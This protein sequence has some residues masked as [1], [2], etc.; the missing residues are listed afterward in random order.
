MGQNCVC[1]FK[2]FETEGQTFN[3]PDINNRNQAIEHGEVLQTNLTKS[4]ISQELSKTHSLSKDAN[5]LSQSKLHN[6]EIAIS[7][8]HK[9][10]KGFLFRKKYHSYLKNQL[11]NYQEE[12]LKEIT[13]A[14]LSNSNILATENKYQGVYTQLGWK[15]YYDYNENKG[16]MIFNNDNPNQK[17]YKNCVYIEY[18]SNNGKES[19]INSLVNK[20]ISL[21]KG[22]VTIDNKRHGYGELLTKENKQKGEWVNDAFTGWNCIFTSDG[23]MLIGKYALGVLNG[24]GEC[25]SLDGYS[26]KGS[27]VNNLKEGEGVEVM[28]NSTY[29]GSFLKD[30]K[31][32]KGKIVFASGDI[33][34]GNFV[35]G[36]IEGKG[37]YIW[38]ISKHEYIGD[39]KGGKFHGNGYYK[40]N[41]E[42]Y[43]KGEY[44]DGVKEGIGEITFP[45]KMKYIGPFANGK[46][47]GVGVFDNGKNFK[48]EA[49]FIDGKINK[50]YKQRK[51]G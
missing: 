10:T 30:M 8:F 23:H 46:P 7:K 49:E 14:L 48:G 24:K 25:Y 40:I 9:Y 26:Y 12:L 13:K 50:K 31:N 15:E 5:Y 47:N 41:G 42:D 1:F 4:P 32:G 6:N 28:N 43:Y 36:V 45:N 38:N 35:N 3:L 20:A 19:V 29:K 16:D 17:S 33:Y 18:I 44:R 27:F 21:Y 2:S 39:Y 22:T 34:E 51:Q 11:F 37:H